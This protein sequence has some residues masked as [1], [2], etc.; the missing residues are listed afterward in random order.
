[1]TYARRDIDRFFVDWKGARS[2]KPLLLRGARQVGKT[3]S[4]RE[5]GKRFSNFIE[6][7]FLL[8]RRAKKIFERELLDPTEICKDISLLYE[9]Q[10]VDGET[11]LFLDEIQECPRAIEALRFFHELRPSLHVV[12]AGSLLEFAVSDIP[13]FGVGR[14]QSVY[15]RPLSFFE[16]LDALGKQTLRAAIEEATFL[17]PLSAVAHDQALSQVKLYLMFGGLPEVVSA[18]RSTRADYQQISAILTT[19]LANYEDDFSKYRGKVP[20]VRLRDCLRA[21][22]YQTGKKFI[23][24]HAYVDAVSTQVHHA[25]ALLEKAGLIVK[26]RHT[27]ANGVP[28]GAEIDEKKFKYKIFDLGIY[29]KLSGLSFRESVL[30]ETA[31]FVHRGPLSEMFVG[32]ELLCLAQSAEPGELWYWHRESKSSTAELDYVAEINH[33]VVPIEVKAGTKGSMR[34]LRIFLAEKKLPFGVRICAENFSRYGDIYVVP[35]YATARLGALL[36]P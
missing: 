30:E 28:L 34:S 15:M 17:K 35:L 21:V 31:N 13:S 16:F 19:L 32:S 22:A 4:V 11:L 27:A 5:L 33:R 7:N 20:D 8:D 14:V 10:I 3:S 24:R 6:L 9:Q 29:Q 36:H 12:A 18:L 2:R 23:Y 25:C 26:V 1:M